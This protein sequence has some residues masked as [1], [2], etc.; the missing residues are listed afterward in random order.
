MQRNAEPPSFPKM[1]ICVNPECGA[2]HTQE[3]YAFQDEP[4]FIKSFTGDLLAVS[5]DPP[6]VYGMIQ[7]ENGGRFMADFTDCALDEVSVGQ[8]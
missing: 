1:D 8:K 3:D 6:A 5:V 2:F 4:A 7:F